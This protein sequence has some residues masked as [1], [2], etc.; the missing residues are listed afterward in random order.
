VGDGGGTSCYATCQCP[1]STARCLCVVVREHLNLPSAHLARSFVEGA[2]SSL[3]LKPI[4]SRI[5]YL[6]ESNLVI[7]LEN[8][9]FFLAFVSRKF[10]HVQALNHIR[11]LIYHLII[12]NVVHSLLVVLL[13]ASNLSDFYSL[14]FVGRELCNC[15][16]LILFPLI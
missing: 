9:P 1:L 2:L 13:I 11:E 12:T 15:S 3:L 10:Y 5:H 7:K 6:L 16:N 4:W 8:H 14:E